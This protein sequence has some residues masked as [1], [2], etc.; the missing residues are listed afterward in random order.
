MLEKSA[1]L[2]RHELRG[3]YNVQ[4]AIL[5][6]DIKM[7]SVMCSVLNLPTFGGHGGRGL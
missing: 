7:N 4:I 6:V 2:L 5:S 1:A 3:Y